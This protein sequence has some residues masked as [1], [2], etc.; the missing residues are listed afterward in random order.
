MI[1]EEYAFRRRQVFMESIY[2]DKHPRI[3]TLTCLLSVILGDTM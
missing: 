2:D 1:M 3:Q